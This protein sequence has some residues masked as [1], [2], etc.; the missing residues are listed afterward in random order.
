MFDGSFVVPAVTATH[1][2]FLGADLEALAWRPISRRVVTPD[3][4]QV[5]GVGL[6]AVQPGVGVC[7]G[8]SHGVR[9]PLALLV[10]P[11]ELHLGRRIK[12]ARLWPLIGNLR[13]F[14]LPLT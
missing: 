9:P 14:G 6:H 8:R 2:S 1:T 12:E 10:V 3:L 11:P 4:D 7:V 5:V 13:R